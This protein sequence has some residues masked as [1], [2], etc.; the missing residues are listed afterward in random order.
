I[1]HVPIVY[2]HLG[3]TFGP[4]I[5]RAACKRLALPR[6][7]RFPIRAMRDQIVLP[8]EIVE[9]LTNKSAISLEIV[10]RIQMLFPGAD[11]KSLSFTRREIRLENN[12][13]RLVKVIEISVH[14]LAE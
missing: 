4:Y 1:H 9:S 14:R 6:D 13:I 10:A 12:D 11:L 8:G 2:D 5:D 3:N 7:Q